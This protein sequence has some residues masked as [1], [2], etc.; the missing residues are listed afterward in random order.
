MR[1][2]GVRVAIREGGRKTVVEGVFGCCIAYATVKAEIEAALV[3]SKS[4]E[5]FKAYCNLCPLKHCWMEKPTG[6]LGNIVLSRLSELGVEVE[7]TAR[8]YIVARIP[9]DGVIEG[10]GTLCSLSALT[11]CSSGRMLVRFLSPR[12]QA[13]PKVGAKGLVAKINELKRSDVARLIKRRLEEFKEVHEADS[14]RWFEELCFCILTANF[15]ASRVLV[16]WE[17]LRRENAFFDADEDELASLLKERGYRFYKKRAEYITGARSFVNNIKEIVLSFEAKSSGASREWLVKSI[18]GV[19]Y[20]EA[21][22]FLRNVGFTDFAIID[23]HILSVLREYG[24]VQLEG[25]GGGRGKNITLTRRR[26]LG[27]E[28]VLRDIA[29]ASGLTLAALDL[30]LW[31]MRT[32]KVVK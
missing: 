15:N 3:S 24:L 21:S 1:G 2:E 10:R 22:H 20:K 5:L 9:G 23:R 7:V 30:Y 11:T 16:I 12:R 26:Y 32:G 14:S 6:D 28:S 13:Q 19:G 27:V 29:E 17:D 8:G 31:Y 4:A 25:G 18:K